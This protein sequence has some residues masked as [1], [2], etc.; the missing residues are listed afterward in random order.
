MPFVIPS[1]VG[2]TP[3]GRLTARQRLQAWERT[4]GACVICGTPID[5]LRQRW[6]VEHLQALELGGADAPDNLGPA[7]ESCGRA[8][9]RDDHARA[10]HAKRCK[11]RHLGVRTSQRPM[12][13]SR[14]SPVKRKLDGSVVARRTRPF[15]PSHDD[16]AL[17]SCSGKEADVIDPGATQRPENRSTVPVIAPT[18]C[19]L[20]PCRGDCEPSGAPRPL[21]AGTE[22]SLSQPA[23]ES[24]HNF[25]ADLDRQIVQHLR[26]SDP[27]EAL[28]VRDICSFVVEA[29]RLRE[30][31][32]QIVDQAQAAAVQQLIRPPLEIE[33]CDTAGRQDAGSAAVLALGWAAG[34]AEPRERVDHLLKE[35]G[36]TCRGVMA[37]AFQLTLTDVE[38]I[39]RMIA[40]ADR[41][42]DALLSTLA[43]NRIA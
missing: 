28:W 41:Q 43:R 31:R 32:S 5:G 26:P 36:L 38:R 1:D 25:A 15:G 10:A 2:T 37:K 21:E 42:R 27:I 18:E 6:I 35:R 16:D 3:R 13:G 39:D 40:A 14:S 20:G 34:H 17:G 29:S 8:K 33:G 4:G 19:H 24:A 7:H 11:A 23:P 30:W 9:T 22:P 12:P